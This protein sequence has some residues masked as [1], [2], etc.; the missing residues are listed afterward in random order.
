MMP[1]LLFRGVSVWGQ[2]QVGKQLHE[3]HNEGG[4]RVL[5][6]GS[7]NWSPFPPP[8][9]QSREQKYSYSYGGSAVMMW[10]THH[11]AI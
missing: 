7:A 10:P 5:R 6:M 1:H 9:A 8:Y 2:Q 3:S 11:S 4:Y